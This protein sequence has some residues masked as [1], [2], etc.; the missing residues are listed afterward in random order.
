MAL[1][2]S[3]PKHRPKCHLV[4]LDRQWAQVVAFHCCSTRGFRDT[5]A[6]A[7]AECRFAVR[8]GSEIPAPRFAA[9]PFRAGML[10]ATHRIARQPTLLAQDHTHTVAASR[11]SGHE[12][13]HCCCT[14]SSSICP[15]AC[16]LAARYCRAPPRSD[17][18]LGTAVCRGQRSVARAPVSVCALRLM[19]IP[20]L[21]PCAGTDLFVWP[22]VIAACPNIHDSEVLVHSLI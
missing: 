18:E 6:S 12:T 17:Q 2:G 21:I 14:A 5:P 10:F 20:R 22:F 9:F 7:V 4:H 13:S 1:G 11:C 8:T 16:T 3:C 15:R 19:R